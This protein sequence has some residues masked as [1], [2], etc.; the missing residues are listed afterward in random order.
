MTAA[1]TTI[2]VGIVTPHAAAGAEAEFDDLAGDQV[3]SRVSRILPPDDDEP[4]TSPSGLRALAQPDIVAR[5]AAKLQPESLDAIVYASTSSAY[6]IGHDAERELVDGLQRRWSTPARST[7]A[8][9]VE[10]L[11]EFGAEPLSLVPPPWF[12]ADRGALGAAYFRDCGFAVAEARLADVD[13]DPDRVTPEQV[14]E[15]VNGNVDRAVDAVV[16]AGNG[17]RAALAVP[18]LESEVDCL[19]VESNQALLW[20]VMRA[21]GASVASDGREACSAEA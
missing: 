11:R 9:I 6:V 2:D 3:R 15:W 1:R 16:L 5:A 17:F 4:P 12:G 14:V 20:S 7:V 18:A 13:G 21:T 19:V 8:S 10:A